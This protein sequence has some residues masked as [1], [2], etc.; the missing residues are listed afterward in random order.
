VTFIKVI[1]F[2]DEIFFRNYSLDI[3]LFDCFSLKFISLESLNTKCWGQYFRSHWTVF[4]KLY[5]WLTNMY[6]L[7][8]PLLLVFVNWWPFPSYVG[9]LHV[10]SSWV[11]LLFINVWLYLFG[12]FVANIKRIVI[13][14]DFLWLWVVNVYLVRYIR[15][16]WLFVNWLWVGAAWGDL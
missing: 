2:L 4:N 14:A 13:G 5:G 10:E 7:F 16:I 11:I 3:E 15:W 12:L 1:G 8:C 9:L 6:V